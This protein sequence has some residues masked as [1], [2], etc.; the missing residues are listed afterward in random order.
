MALQLF[1]TVGFSAFPL[2]LYVPPIRSLTLFV[3]RMED[4]I[5]D[6]TDNTRVL[7]PLL[8]RFSSTFF[9]FILCCNSSD[10]RRELKQKAFLHLHKHIQELSMVW[11]SVI[12]VTFVLS[13]NLFNTSI[14]GADVRILF[15]NVT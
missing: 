9:N 15:I 10:I 8:R 13:G 5:R 12:V 2:T 6:S 7:Y 14:S 3:E 11:R 4:F 1:I